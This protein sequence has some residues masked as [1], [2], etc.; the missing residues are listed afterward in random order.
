[1]K[2]SVLG[3]TFRIVA[4]LLV[5]AVQARDDGRYMQSPL[6][7]DLIRALGLLHKFLHFSTSL[8]SGGY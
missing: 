1:M 5:G 4:A 2:T 3:F 7:H 6:K 8:V